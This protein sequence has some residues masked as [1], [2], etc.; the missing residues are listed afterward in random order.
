MPVCYDMD[1]DYD[2]DEPDGLLCSM[3]GSFINGNKLIFTFK[4]NTPRSVSYTY[5]EVLEILKK[6][7]DKEIYLLDL[8]EHEE[9]PAYYGC[10]V[11]C[12]FFSIIAGRKPK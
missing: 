2:S 11:G 1:W 3:T 4:R 8:D 5:S 9:K 7:T 12:T 10:S 6:N